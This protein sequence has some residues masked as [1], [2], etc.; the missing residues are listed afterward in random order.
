MKFFAKKSLITTALMILSLSSV[1]QSRIEPVQPSELTAEQKKA[2]E[3]FFQSRKAPLTGPFL[4]LLH[5]PEMLTNASN[6]GLY[7][8]YRSALGNQLSEMIILL[9]ARHF[10][11]DYEW[12]VHAPIALREKISEEIIEAIRDGRRPVKMTD[13]ETM[14]YNFAYELLQNKRVSDSSYQAVEK[15]WGKKGAIDLTGIVGY[16][17]LLAMELNM[18]N[19]QISDPSKK[20]PRFPS[21]R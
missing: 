15:R 5:S 3:E 9:T 20:L 1:A 17:S 16:Y 4:V 6:M 14:A 18:A 10:T 19:H 11:Q 21:D 7:L 8:R 12:F 2:A 13:D